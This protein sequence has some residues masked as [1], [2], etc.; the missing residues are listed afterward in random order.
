MYGGPVFTLDSSITTMYDVENLNISI[1]YRFDRHVYTF[2]NPD[3]STTG[4]VNY[5]YDTNGNDK[6]YFSNTAT[7]QIS[8]RYKW[9][10]A[11]LDNF[12]QHEDVYWPK[13]RVH[14]PSETDSQSSLSYDVTPFGSASDI[15][16]S[17]A[18]IDIRVISNTAYDF[19][20]ATERF[21]LSSGIV[22][23]TSDKNRQDA[24]R[25]DNTYSKMIGCYGD[26]YAPD[27]QEIGT[28]YLYSGYLGTTFVHT[29]STGNAGLKDIEF[30]TRDGVESLKH[31][32]RVDVKNAEVWL[33][34]LGIVFTGN[35]SRPDYLGT[36]CFGMSVSGELYNSI[37]AAGSYGL[38][39]PYEYAEAILRHSDPDAEYNVASW[40][41][42]EGTGWVPYFG[43]RRDWS[44]FTL[45]KK[46]NLRDFL[47]DFFEYEP[48]TVYK[49]ENNQYKLVGFPLTTPSSQMTID[50]DDCNDFDIVNTDISKVVNKISSLKQGYLPGVDDYE[51]DTQ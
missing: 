31:A 23:F 3:F 11:F 27:Q 42:Y 20:S 46:T 36:E 38:R 45:N 37:S 29:S 32:L 2:V 1:P 33:A 43:Q 12:R 34:G 6:Y 14:I 39:R 28:D 44:G 47:N 19:T 41:A 7:P 26:F 5:A 9:N 16:P 25:R 13:R 8:V 15:Q 18:K 4:S 48:Y 30:R 10:N 21:Y 24:Y 17:G 35:Y 50:F 40:S 49:N 22:G 51:N